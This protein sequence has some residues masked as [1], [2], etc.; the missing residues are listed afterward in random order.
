MSTSWSRVRVYHNGKIRVLRTQIFP[1]ERDETTSLAMKVRLGAE[2]VSVRLVPV[3]S[4]IAS[5]VRV[6]HGAQVYAVAWGDVLLFEQAV[7]IADSVVH[8][9]LNYLS[10]AVSLGKNLLFKAKTFDELSVTDKL[11][12]LR[13]TL[14]GDV[15]IADQ[16]VS[17]VYTA[18]TVETRY[19]RGDTHDVNL[20]TAYVLGTSQ[21]TLPST[22]SYCEAAGTGS[23]PV[24]WGIRVY[25]REANGTITELGDAGV[26]KAQVSRSADGEGT[27]SATWVCPETA[28]GTQDAIQ[29]EVAQSISSWMSAA[30]FITEQLDSTLLAQSTWTVYYY[31]K[32]YYDIFEDYT[33][34]FFYWGDSTLDSRIEDF[35]YRIV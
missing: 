34:G 27:Q 23:F 33:C 18:W 5:P 21:S 14:E 4:P 30:T 24:T 13:P 20:L 2:T 19:M 8:R 28:M 29:V 25:R 12:K 11:K 9:L 7:G 3:T 22:F 10:E 17:N 32:R 16:I 31:T 35:K 6:Y 1:G 26:Y 15:A